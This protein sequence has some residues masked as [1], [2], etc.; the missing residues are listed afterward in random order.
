MKVDQFFGYHAEN[1]LY[2]VLVVIFCDYR[3]GIYPKMKK[4]FKSVSTLIM[5][6]ML[7]ITFASCTSRGSKTDDTTTTTEYSTSLTERPVNTAAVVTYFN[8][9][10]DKAVT[11]PDEDKPEIEWS[12]SMMTT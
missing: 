4:T 5:A 11:A 12:E 9:L 1:N 6:L 7:L 2:Y 8:S 10:L 3:K